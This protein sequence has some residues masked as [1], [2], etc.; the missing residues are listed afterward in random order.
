MWF[1]K[2]LKGPERMKPDQARLNKG[3]NTHRVSSVCIALLGMANQPA[4]TGDAIILFFP[5]SLSFLGAVSISTWNPGPR[6]LKVFLLLT[7]KIKKKE[8]TP[9]VLVQ[10]P[11]LT[12]IEAADLQ[13]GMGDAFSFVSFLPAVSNSNSNSELKSLNVFRA[14]GKQRYFFSKICGLLLYR[15]AEPGVLSGSS[16]EGDRLP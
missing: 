16:T 4:L 7:K 13:G 3:K 9:I 2:L 15:Q 12:H 1:L 5:S 6:S 14:V 8:K 11:P 10:H